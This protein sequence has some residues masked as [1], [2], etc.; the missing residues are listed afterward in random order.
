[1]KAQVSKEACVSDVGGGHEE[2]RVAFRSEKWGQR[3]WF[4]LPE[5]QSEET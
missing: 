2:V 4:D 5:S 3:T 1:M